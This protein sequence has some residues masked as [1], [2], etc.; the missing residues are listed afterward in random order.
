MAQRPLLFLTQEGVEDGHEKRFRFP[1]PGPR[2]DHD[3]SPRDGLANG[4]FLVH[5]QWPFVGKCLVVTAERG[6]PRGED[7]LFH[8]AAQGFSW[9]ERGR[10]FQ[11]GPLHQTSWFFKGLGKLA[12]QFGILKGLDGLQ[13]ADVRITNGFGDF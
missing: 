4:P 8:Q 5:V 12:S 1:T 10:Y 7:T 9:A 6:K 3:V 11:N 13:V 2:A